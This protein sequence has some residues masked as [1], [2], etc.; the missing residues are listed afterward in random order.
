MGKEFRQVVSDVSITSSKEYNDFLYG[1]LVL[2][3]H[4]GD[5]VYVWKGDFVLSKMEQELGMTRKTIAKYFSFLVKEGL[6]VEEEDRYILPSL[7]KK[8][9]GIE[10]D[11][12]RRLVETKERYALTLYA[13]LVRGYYI[14]GRQQYTVLLD[15][16]KRQLGLSTESR[17]NSK[18][19]TN[20]FEMFREM[21]L[22][23]CTLNMDKSK[24]KRYY[25][26]D[27]V[28]KDYYF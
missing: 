24:I 16:A 28:G 5:Q 13:Y 15:N 20:L 10:V 23:K 18:I 27:G 9:F 25:T 2:N 22:L 17:S 1:W 14:A 26:L 19:V 12:L 11:V 3:A 7:G 6:V 21:G 8:G 4:M